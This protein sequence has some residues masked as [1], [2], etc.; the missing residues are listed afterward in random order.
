M[1][2]FGRAT[3]N[4]QLR[5]YEPTMAE[6]I[7]IALQGMFG[8]LGLDKYKARSFAKPIADALEWSPVGAAAAAIDA[9]V[10]ARKSTTTTGMFGNLA[11][12]AALAA[13]GAVPGGKAL[14]GAVND[15][16]RGIV[17]YH[18]SPHTFDKFSLDK[19]GTGEGAQAYGHGLYFAE[20]EGVARGYRDKLAGYSPD[21][22]VGGNNLG[23]YNPNLRSGENSQRIAEQFGVDVNDAH[24]IE[25]ALRQLH[26]QSWNNAP[27]SLDGLADK[28]S[29]GAGPRYAEHIK[30]KVAEL[31][32][33][34]D[35]VE[36]RKPGSMYQVR[37]NADPAD[38][39][40][41]DKPLAE[42]SDKVRAAL[43]GTAPRNP[44]YESFDPNRIVHEPEMSG[45]AIY[46]RIKIGEGGSDAA[47]NP[48]RDAGVAGIKYL[49]AGSRG[50]GDGSRNFVV[51][52][53]KLI[54]ILKRYGWVPGTAVPT[55]L[56]ARAQSEAMGKPEA[57][58]I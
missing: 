5:A 48:L 57:G 39:L 12:G 10:A 34:L 25:G 58:G 49:D 4:D 50:A 55:A 45:R 52:N 29:Q 19:I 47:L 26:E 14:R 56:M 32:P 24:V 15:A 9:G 11:G 22:V 41:W 33:K 20:N 31:A 13:L 28:L 42:Q 3:A 40:D 21:L 18:G 8:K 51:F 44:L 53:D 35:A 30:A 6:R 23:G 38:F 46:D 37:I 17:A 43:A 16:R 2:M 1:A 54:D 27:R 7:P 36:F